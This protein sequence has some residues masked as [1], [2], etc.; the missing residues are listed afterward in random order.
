MQF[1]NLSTS[2]KYFE[3]LWGMTI[4]KAIEFMSKPVPSNKG[5]IE[6]RVVVDEFQRGNGDVVMYNAR[7]E[8]IFTA[9]RKRGWDGL[10]YYAIYVHNSTKPDMSSLEPSFDDSRL[11]GKVK[12]NLMG[13]E[14]RSYDNGKEPGKAKGMIDIRKQICVI[15]FAATL[16]FQPRAL[17][18]FI[19]KVEEHGGFD[20]DS[21]TFTSRQFKLWKRE[22]DDLAT[23]GTNIVRMA[24]G[25][26]HLPAVAEGAD[27][28]GISF[29]VNQAPIWN[30]GEGMYTLDF[31]GR[32]TSASVKNFMLERPIRKKDPLDPTICDDKVKGE[33]NQQDTVIIFGRT[34]Y[35]PDQYNLDFSFPFSPLQAFCCALSSLDSH[36][37]CE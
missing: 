13:S 22:G 8:L 20:E 18:V 25:D 15:Q 21:Q 12:G 31:M 28:H 26:E 2:R 3:K 29:F 7:D 32:V 27:E 17:K 24:G 14:F 19:P 1:N 34:G 35:E 16:G 9:K 33:C 10:R 4:P 30:E 11:A 6:T 37:I 36:L 5:R 23:I